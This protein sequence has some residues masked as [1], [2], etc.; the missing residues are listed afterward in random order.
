MENE[1]TFL[2]GGELRFRN[3]KNESREQVINSIKQAGLNKKIEKINSQDR[4]M[5]IQVELKDGSFYGKGVYIFEGKMLRSTMMYAI[6][7]KELYTKMH[8]HL[9][10]RRNEKEDP[11]GY[12]FHMKQKVEKIKKFDIN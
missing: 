10:G 9:N 4:K 8:D 11:I 5:K 3:A 6:T 2:R 1:I 12:V 7:L